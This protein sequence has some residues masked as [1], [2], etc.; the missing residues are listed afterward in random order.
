VWCCVVRHMVDV[1]LK[2]NTAFFFRFKQLKQNEG[3]TILWNI[4]NY[5]PTNTEHFS[6]QQ[7]HCE[8]LK[9]CK[10]GPGSFKCQ[11][12]STRLQGVTVQ[13]TVKLTLT[14]QCTIMLT[15]LIVQSTVTLTL[16]VQCNVILTLTVQ[17][18]AILTTLTV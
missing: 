17:C 12:L 2:E 8:S 1:V 16:T 3:S 9:A 10:K 11:Y 14:V 15:A 6:H 5:L 13:I 7:H 4:R 18:T